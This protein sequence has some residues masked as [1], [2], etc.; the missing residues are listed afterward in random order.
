M[1]VVRVQSEKRMVEELEGV[2]RVLRLGIRQDWEKRAQAVRKCVS[3]AENA[4]TSSSELLMGA[5]MRGLKSIV[6][7]LCENVTDTKAAVVKASCEA[8]IGLSECLGATFGHTLAG[9]ILSALQRTA[10]S[11][12]NVLSEYATEAMRSIL[13][14]APVPSTVLDEVCKSSGSSSTSAC[15]AAAECVAVILDKQ[16]RPALDTCTGAISKAILEGTNHN[17]LAVAQRSLNNFCILEMLYPKVAGSLHEELSEEAQKKVKFAREE[18]DLAPRKCK[19][20]AYLSHRSYPKWKKVRSPM[21]TDTAQSVTDSNTK[22]S[23]T[24]IGSSMSRPVLEE[25]SHSSIGSK[26]WPGRVD[27]V[28]AILSTAM[29]SDATWTSDSIRLAASYLNDT[30]VEV[31]ISALNV[32][33]QL[34]ELGEGACNTIEVDPMLTAKVFSRKRSSHEKVSMAVNSVVE[35]MKERMG[36]DRY[37][38]HLV[39]VLAL[40]EISEMNNARSR[41]L[42][43]VLEVVLAEVKSGSW[44]H[45]GRPSLDVNLDT[46]LSLTVSLSCDQ[47]VMVSVAAGK[48]LLAMRQIAP[49]LQYTEALSEYEVLRSE[50]QMCDSSRAKIPLPDISTIEKVAQSAQRLSRGSSRRDASSLSV[51]FSDDVSPLSRRGSIISR[52]LLF[53]NESAPVYSTTAKNHKKLGKSNRKPLNNSTNYFLIQ[54]EKP[55]L[56]AVLNS[57]GAPFRVEQLD[58]SVKENSLYQIF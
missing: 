33:V 20:C 26:H 46:L 35:T 53:E 15:L 22:N 3:L 38:K 32:L 9:P 10:T 44:G 18:F 7:F 52:E 8:M 34:I 41:M 25:D 37:A 40:S 54:P 39:D 36:L 1:E 6:Y 57:V 4:V 2:K 47:D 16:P 24:S 27:E 55:A 14:N 28:E 42:C 58:A 30:Q 45:R 51:S 56:E 17:V 29:L 11:S 48:L 21:S 31:L 19:T 13:H 5:L 23:A 43:S 50:Q 12:S 49:T